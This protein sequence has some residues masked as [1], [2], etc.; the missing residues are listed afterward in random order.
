MA[1]EKSVCFAD[2]FILPLMAASE[3]NLRKGNLFNSCQDVSLN[4]TLVVVLEGVCYFVSVHIQEIS[5]YK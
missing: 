2:M 5:V 1:E 3:E 4:N